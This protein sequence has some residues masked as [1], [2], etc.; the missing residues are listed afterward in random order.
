MFPYNITT[1]TFSERQIYFDLYGCGETIGQNSIKS[2]V[3]YLK[4]EDVL[5]YVAVP[6]VRVVVPD[7]PP[8]K[9]QQLQPKSNSPG[10]TDLE[11]VFGWLRDQ[12]N[13]KT[14]L[15]VIVD[16]LQEP[17]HSD[18]SI[19]TS[20]KGLNVEHWDWRK[21]D[22]CVEVIHAVAPRARVVNLYW[23]GNNAVLR[24]WGEPEGLAKLEKLERVHLHERQVSL[25]SIIAPI[26]PF[27]SGIASE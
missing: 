25:A 5:Q 13:V 3:E 10:R 8:P 2:S 16:D 15:R 7:Q 21:T 6:Q 20:L 14:I 23:S 11:Y 26:A 9:K 27:R 12:R 1:L 19:E 18:E 22:L 4:F 24:G 17:A